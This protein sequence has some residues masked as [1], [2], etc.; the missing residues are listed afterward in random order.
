MGHI[1]GGP[2]ESDYQRLSLSM[3]ATAHLNHKEA[4][5]SIMSYL[6]SPPLHI[7][8]GTEYVSKNLA[9]APRLGT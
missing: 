7:R 8:L 5:P 4:S 2:A 6:L 3:N 1:E 9:T